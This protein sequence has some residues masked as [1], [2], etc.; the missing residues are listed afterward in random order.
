MSTSY[1]YEKQNKQIDVHKKCCLICTNWWCGYRYPGWNGLDHLNSTRVW[2][3][4]KFTI[5]TMSSTM[6][7][8]KEVSFCDSHWIKFMFTPNKYLLCVLYKL[9]WYNVMWL[10]EWWKSIFF[11]GQIY[12]PFPKIMSLQLKR[13]ITRNFEI[14]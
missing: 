14:N 4:R 8:R 9:H 10:Y 13:N 1:Q 3:T 11:L 7:L 2:P 12:I 5:L 6:F